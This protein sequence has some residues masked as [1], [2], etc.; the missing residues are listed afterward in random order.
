M[1]DDVQLV[2]EIGEVKAELSG[3]Q[4]RGRGHQP[5]SRRHRDHPA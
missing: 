4:G 1:N 5:A 2:R 3:L